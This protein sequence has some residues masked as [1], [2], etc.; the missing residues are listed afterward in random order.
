MKYRSFSYYALV[1]RFNSPGVAK[2]I[3]DT[4]LA[5]GHIG[6][7]ASCNLYPTNRSGV[8]CFFL[9][10]LKEDSDIIMIRFSDL[11]F[12]LVFFVMLIQRLRGRIIIIDVPTPRVV[13]LK[14]MDSAIK[15]PTLRV[16]RK[17]LTV[18]SAAW[19][20]YP[21][22]KVIQ[23]AEESAWFTLGVKNKT[24]KIGNGILIDDEITLTQ[25]VWPN[26][27]LQL[28][29][30]AQLAKW[31]GFDRILKAI[32]LLNKKNLTYRVAFTI[33]GDGGELGYLRALTR[34]LGL[35]AQITFTG[36]LL[37]SDLDQFF[38]QAHIGISSLGLYRKG[39][40]EASDLKTREYM[41]RG[42]PVIGVGADPDFEKDSAFRFVV[43]ND[44]SI[45]EL[46]ELI[47]SFADSK[48]PLPTDVRRFAEERL[49][50]ESKL[51]KILEI[52]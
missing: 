34:E 24:L 19:V 42:L 11:V 45:E 18:V 12:P 32:A 52:R 3:D 13:S 47:A 17:M 28:I 9:K 26:K 6:L 51:S 8:F 10:L 43:A 21:A 46:A 30:V 33:V 31:H 2:K 27:E 40:T 4:V 39:L 20:L 15:N 36:M 49:S 48:L 41:A 1:N 14:E 5:A 44:E 29:G 23:Y 22:N 16:L 38:T 7:D 25:A 35:G 37:G 50:L